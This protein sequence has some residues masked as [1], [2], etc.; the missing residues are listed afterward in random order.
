MKDYSKL[1]SEIQNS[2]TKPDT[3]L[4]SELVKA[5]TK[6]RQL[7]AEN[8]ALRIRPLAITPKQATNATTASTG[9]TISR[10]DFTAM[11]HL[12]R[13]KLMRQCVKITN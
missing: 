1:L 2:A 3:G 8:K 7:E 12:E 4:L 6:I 10:S 11:H 9:Q 5:Q 13:N